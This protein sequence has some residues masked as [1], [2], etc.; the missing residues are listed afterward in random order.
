MALHAHAPGES[1]FHVK[2]GI[3]LATQTYFAKHVDG[4]MA[5]LLA[6][7]QD[8]RLRAFIEQTLLA[9]GWYDVLPVAPLIDAEARAAR[10]P[11]N[12][13]LRERARFQ[14]KVDLGGVYKFILWLASPDSVALR[15]PRM[16][17]QLFDFGRIEILHKEPRFVRAE[18][19][20][21]PALLSVWYVNAFDV[22]CEA[23]LKAAGAG[24]VGVSA[25]TPKIVETRLGVE[26]ASFTLDVRWSAASA[27]NDEPPSP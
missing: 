1:P 14:A 2:G 11:L 18:L 25:S 4:G 26:L 15:L 3:Y 13:Y 24:L 8:A 21:F 9:S 23:A 12:T 27:A 17:T 10:Q 5:S 20:G 19:S 6:E 7:I 16:L 22:Y